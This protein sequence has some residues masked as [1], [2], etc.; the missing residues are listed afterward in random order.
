MA[1]GAK[2]NRER[3]IH[4]AVRLIDRDGPE[5]FS[6]R[7]IANE[8]GAGA[9]SLYNHVRDK[10]AVLDGVAEYVLAEVELPAEDSADW[11][12]QVRE[13]ARSFR[14]V[15]LAHPRA[16][17][18]VLSRQLDSTLGL[19]PVEA[20]LLVLRRAGFDEATAVHALRAFLAFQVGSIL[21]EVKAT[22]AFSGLDAD[23]VRQR[24]DAL[25]GS[26]FPAVA[27]AAPLLAVCDHE[28]E[29][30]FG[31]EALLA[32]L[33]SRGVHGGQIDG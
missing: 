33:S 29:Y 11:Q 32:A 14:R 22:A 8:L 26:G 19:R 17:A 4:A 7:R 16:A 10:A 5:A 12:E 15:A 21:R 20:A 30:E 13:L 18:L 3:I 24:T 23:G 25:R 9:M 6:M 2:L 27:A 1:E 28:A 31:I